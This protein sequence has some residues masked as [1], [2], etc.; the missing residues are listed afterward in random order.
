MVVAG[1][2]RCGDPAGFYN[3]GGLFFP[4]CRGASRGDVHSGVSA[5]G[6]I[7][8]IVYNDDGKYEPEYYH[9]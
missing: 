8:D 5:L 3:E 4:V 6:D 1:A 7:R 2:A 9:F